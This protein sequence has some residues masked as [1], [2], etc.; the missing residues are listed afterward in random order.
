LY[1]GSCAS[2]TILFINNFFPKSSGAQLAY[3]KRTQY[4]T[5]LFLHDLTTGN[6]VNLFQ[7]M[8]FDQQESSAPAGRVWC[9]MCGVCMVCVGCV[10]LCLYVC[11]VYVD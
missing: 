3:I 4:T 2:N 11:V 10:C 6:D 5:S 9:C 8:D 7:N 1:S